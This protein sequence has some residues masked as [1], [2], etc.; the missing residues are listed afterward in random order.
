MRKKIRCI[1]IIRNLSIIVLILMSC[2]T[3]LGCAPSA[4]TVLEN[5]DSYITNGDYE[6]AESQLLAALDKTPDSVELKK[7]ISE[8]YRAQAMTMVSATDALECFEKAQEYDAEFEYTAEELNFLC[9]TA[10]QTNDMKKEVFEICNEKIA[11]GKD[12]IENTQ[13][14]QL[15]ISVAMDE[16][17]AST[18]KIILD[19]LYNVVQDEAILQAWVQLDLGVQI[20]YKEYAEDL[21]I[22]RTE[23]RAECS[24]IR[25]DLED[26]K[27]ENLYSYDT[28]A[29][30]KEGNVLYASRA[31][32]PYGGDPN[33]TG[34]RRGL[35]YTYNESG[36]LV[37][38]ESIDH[39]KLE[40]FYDE[41]NNVIS[42][43]YNSG[44]KREPYGSALERSGY[45]IELNSGEQY[46]L[47]TEFINNMQYLNIICAGNKIVYGKLFTV[48]NTIEVIKLSD[49]TTEGDKGFIQ[50]ANQ[51]YQILERDA[52]GNI[53]YEIILEYDK[54][55]MLK[56]EITK[57]YLLNTDEC[58][59]YVTEE[60]ED[61]RFYVRVPVNVRMVEELGTY[62]I[63][64]AVGESAHAS[65][66]HKVEYDWYP[67][68]CDGVDTHY[69]IYCFE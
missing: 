17:S 15:G 21:N 66:S 11:E 63:S 32:F 52:S 51:K 26:I 34:L 45:T 41:N 13:Y 5:V 37:F 20:D 12:I 56:K 19:E 16:G 36:N 2:V 43:S 67:Y 44:D 65:V 29:Y 49:G 23:N 57:D 10:L 69:E 25:L 9:D 60:I 64:T 27:E 62:K 6:T 33:Q 31:F 55:G 28:Y 61:G 59:W 40:L 58:L 24:V 7:K 42:Y 22:C 53:V 8:M 30:N 3:I 4:E 38:V 50:Y 48:G 46:L 54:Y 35:T 68:Y 1:A 47:D 14:V 39:S 18:G